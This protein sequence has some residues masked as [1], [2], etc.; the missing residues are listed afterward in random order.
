MQLWHCLFLS[1]GL[2]EFWTV[3]SVAI[4]A[5]TRDLNTNSAHRIQFAVKRRSHFSVKR[6]Q[7]TYLQVYHI[8]ISIFF[9]RLSQCNLLS[10][11]LWVPFRDCPG[12]CCSPLEPSHWSLSCRLVFV[13]LFQPAKSTECL[14]LS[15]LKVK[16]TA[17]DHFSAFFFFF[18]VRLSSIISE[19]LILCMFIII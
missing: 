12:P 8:T 15:V 5:Q 9:P 10:F 4:S 16:S 13:F 11:S 18:L 3:T 7:T 1:A 2:D 17:S 6:P 14:C 19:N